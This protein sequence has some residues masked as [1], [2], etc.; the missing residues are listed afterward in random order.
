[1]TS[2]LFPVLVLAV[3]LWVSGVAK[4]RSPGSV[5]SAFTELKVPGVFDRA[6]IQRIFPWAEILLGVLLLVAPG[7]FAPVTAIAAVV[8]FAAYWALIYQALG[9]DAP[10]SCNCFGRASTEPVT[11]WTL[12]RN[13]ALLALSVFWAVASFFD[14]VPS[15]LSRA[16]GNDVLWIVGIVCA[17]GTL[18]LAISPAS[19]RA[20]AAKAD[21]GRGS[22]A[23]SDGPVSPGAGVAPATPEAD[24]DDYVRRPIPGVVVKNS[25]DEMVALS[26]LAAVRARLLIYVSPGCGSCS[27]TIAG[28]VEWSRDLDP[29]V[30]VHL[31]TSAPREA[32]EVVADE[33]LWSEALYEV[34]GFMQEFLGLAGTP[35][36]VLLGAD[37][38]LAG[39]PVVG[40][41][42]ITEFVGEIQ[43]ELADA[44]QEPDPRQERA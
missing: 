22:G 37:G 33:S 41:Q 28:A 25:K 43:D 4:L 2:L 14:S 10:V 24:D 5:A 12:W 29:A 9:F 7:W 38:L 20:A 44:Q 27:E 32:L 8:L 1:M 18:Y 11:H 17:T 26:H 36:A 15:L 23:V 39:G 19:R 3:V 40:P 13:T 30:Q 6:W 31:V 42:A 16:T 34:G 35:S 21:A